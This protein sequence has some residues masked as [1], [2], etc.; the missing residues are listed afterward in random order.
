MGLRIGT[1][2][3]VR[4]KKPYT[5]PKRGTSKEDMKKVSNRPATA[6][7]ISTH[8]SAKNVLV[9]LLINCNCDVTVALV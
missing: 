5:N 1:N 2:V 4:R 9:Y 3:T 8:D 7:S 6:P